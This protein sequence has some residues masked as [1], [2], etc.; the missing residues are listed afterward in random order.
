MKIKQNWEEGFFGVQH[1]D[2]LDRRRFT[3]QIQDDTFLYCLKRRDRTALIYNSR[4]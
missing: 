2:I 1:R 4:V 3:V